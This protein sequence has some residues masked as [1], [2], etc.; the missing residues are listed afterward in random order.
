MAKYPAARAGDP[1]THDGISPCGT[2]APRGGGPPV[3]IE[4]Q[5][6]ATV[7]FPFACDGKTG[8]GP[9]H[10]PVPAGA[11]FSGSST[12]FVNGAPL[13][14]WIP[15]GDSGTCGVFLGKAAGG[16][17][18]FVGGDAGDGGCDDGGD[19]SDAGCQTEDD[20]EYETVVIQ[21][22]F[23]KTFESRHE[24]QGKD[25]T[26]VRENHS[27]HRRVH[28]AFGR[29]RKGASKT[30]VEPIRVFQS[31]QSIEVNRDISNLRANYYVITYRYSP[32]AVPQGGPA[33]QFPRDRSE[34]LDQFAGGTP[35]KPPADARYSI[36]EIAPR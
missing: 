35:A 31:V 32:P 9:A 17:T 30:M 34:M 26:F 22:V 36:P 6:A 4:G 33:V 12:V 28:V 15:S 13:A 2:I 24:R 3:N 18:V 16:R 19:G 8:I 23:M 5:V 29:A 1:I 11:V 27:E 14:R 20:E 10:P 25:A 21:E 7:G